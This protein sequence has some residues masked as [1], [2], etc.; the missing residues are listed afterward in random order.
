MST[1]ATEI[2]QQAEIKGHTN[3]A[4]KDIEKVTDYAEEAEVD[5]AKLSEA[6]NFLSNVNGAIQSKKKEGERIA[7]SK[8]D[9]ELLVNYNYDD[10]VIFKAKELQIS[11]TAA[12]KA[13]RE[14]KGDFKEAFKCLVSSDIY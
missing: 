5:A 11:K 8:E 9:V 13:I 4:R 1:D 2:E 6:M 12:E 10:N 7:V 3:Q 14:A